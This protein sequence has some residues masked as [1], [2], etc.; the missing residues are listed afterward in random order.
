MRST[1][2]YVHG[3]RTRGGKEKEENEEANINQLGLALSWPFGGAEGKPAAYS[4][5]LLDTLPRWREIAVET[6]QKKVR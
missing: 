1:G 4:D 2:K 6:G 5:S 3:R